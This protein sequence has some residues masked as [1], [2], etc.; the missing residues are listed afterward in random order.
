MDAATKIPST[1]AT[2][3]EKQGFH[4]R[5]KSKSHADMSATLEALS[6]T[7]FEPLN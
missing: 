1:E 5:K 3:G 2:N 7:S 6:D 4:E